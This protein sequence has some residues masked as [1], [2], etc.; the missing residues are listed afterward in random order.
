MITSKLKRNALGW[1]SS[2]LII[3]LIL[4]ALIAACRPS[5]QGAGTAEQA[6][7]DYFAALNAGQYEQADRL[8]GG[9]YETLTGW[10]PDI[11]PDDHTALWEAGCSR[12]GLQCLLVRSFSLKEQAGDI[13]FYTVEF[14][15]KDG[16]LFVRG[17]CCGADE[18][19]MPSTSQFEVR[20]QESE[21][22]RF[23][24]LD[25]PVYIP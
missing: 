14:T 22:G 20:V 15:N 4:A 10:N 7:Q 9:T 3:F 5:S 2:H 11:N 23:L 6:L 16:D 13:Y 17:P 8:F 21:D 19:E 24:V 12:N 18:T 1:L 25:L